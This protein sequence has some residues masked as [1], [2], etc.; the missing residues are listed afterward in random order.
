MFY[1]RHNT[2]VP[3]LPD[4]VCL[5]AWLCLQHGPPAPRCWLLGETKDPLVKLV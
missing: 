2:L 5:G 4:T 3:R 1:A